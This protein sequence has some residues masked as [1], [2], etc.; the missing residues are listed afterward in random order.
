[1][2]R[3]DELVSLFFD[4]E[5]S[6]AELDEISA[7]LSDDRERAKDFQQQL[8]IWEAWSQETAPERSAEAFVAAFHTRLRAE[9]D[10]SDFELAVTKQ[11]KERKN[12][13]LFQPVFAIAAVLI[14]LLSLTVL[15]K[16]TDPESQM[17]EQT[18]GAEP[19]T[20]FVSIAGECV[21]THCTLK[22][23]GKHNKAIR[24][25]DANGT[26]QI[27]LLSRN[28][29]LRQHSRKFCGG[30]TPVLVK[31]EIVEQDGQQM[32][33]TASLDFTEGKIL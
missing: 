6:D 10:A 17:A 12:P 4:G 14:I 7:M 15:L 21:C 24:Y 9:E 23:E 31:G 1:M 5:P 25:A 8:L 20:R 18:D 16:P 11:L 32:L 28:P 33:T 30:P 29:K 22:M 27:M 2:T 19:H 26:V 13:F 3:Y